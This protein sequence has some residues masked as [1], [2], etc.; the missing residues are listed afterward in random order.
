MQGSI[1]IRLTTG[2]DTQCVDF[3]GIILADESEDL[4]GSVYR[5]RFLAKGAPAPAD[6]GSPSGAFVD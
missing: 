4:G 5:G 2:A 3:G 1:G 6:C